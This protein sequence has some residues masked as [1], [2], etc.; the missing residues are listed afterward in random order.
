M[1]Q[2]LKNLFL[3][4]SMIDG[5]VRSFDA[6][7]AITGPNVGE[8]FSEYLIHIEG[9]E[10]AKLHVYPRND[11]TFTLAAAVGKNQPLSLRVAEHV[12]ENCKRKQHEQ[13]PLTLEHISQESWAF[14]L[15]HLADDYGFEVTE[16]AVA[17]G[18]RFDIK[19]GH[20]DYVNLN[21]YNKNGNLLM[22][23]KAREVYSTIV[24][25]L[26][27]HLPDK[28]A[29][30]EAQLKT[31]DVSDVKADHLFDELRQS[32]PS[33]IDLLGDTGA[34]IIAPALALS[35]L[36]IELPD[37]SCIAYH[38]LRG[39]ECYVKAIM[40]KHDCP[41]QNAAGFGNYLDATGAR[42]KIGVRAKMTHEEA[43]AV[44]E[45]YVLLK[46]DRN[47]LFHADA[48]PEMSRIL[49]DKAEANNILHAVLHLI[50]RT[51]AAIP[52]HA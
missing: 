36:N 27:D 47:P 30:V 45:G 51:A 32:V 50:E 6:A 9:Q 31:Y 8:K 7:A 52:N 3:D 12:A 22:Q 49:P 11:N 19:K 48:N 10:I 34:A 44:E 4:P 42:L 26:S 35:K 2:N 5:A 20:N 33:A 25:I 46:A 41:V 14:L 18:V 13:R 28:R 17:H 43:I 23:G 16:R 39:L 24:E 37:Y 40:A 15:K 29:L 21:R 38:A 1:T